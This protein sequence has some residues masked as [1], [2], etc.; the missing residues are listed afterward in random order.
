MNFYTATK[1]TNHFG[2]E[3]MRKFMRKEQGQL[4]NLPG[5]ENRR[6]TC[7]VH[8]CVHSRH[9]HTVLDHSEFANGV[10]ACTTD[11]LSIQRAIAIYRKQ[12]R[13]GPTQNSLESPLEE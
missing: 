11:V 4:T 9:E 8:F 2:A 13:S 6:T 5:L 3:R 7:G 12:P 10:V 1:K